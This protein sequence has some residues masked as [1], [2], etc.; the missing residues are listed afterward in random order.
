VRDVVVNLLASLVA[1]SAAWLA[2]WLLRYRRLARRRAF[3]GVTKGEECRLVVGRQAGAPSEHSVNRRDVAALVEL[4][5]VV[6]ACGGR[7]NLETTVDTVGRRTEFCVGGPSVNPRMAAHL[8]AMLPGVRMTPVE[9]ERVQGHSGQLVVGA[10]SY[11]REAGRSEYVVLAKAYPPD[12]RHPVFLLCGQTAQSNAAAARL[13]G[14]RYRRLIRD[15]GTN[16]PFCLV[17]RIV[18]PGIYGPDFVELAADVT[19]EAFQPAAAFQPATG[20]VGGSAAEQIPRQPAA[21]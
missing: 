11:T 13:L 9:G 14:T 7:A 2:Q 3:F 19:A 12:R 15:Y 18:E 16:A 6:R 10:T 1:A 4:A 21:G 8:R 20:A 5:A 17:L